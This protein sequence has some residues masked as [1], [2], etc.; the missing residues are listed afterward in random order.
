MNNS[1]LPYPKKFQEVVV[2]RL[3]NRDNVIEDGRLFWWDEK[4]YLFASEVNTKNSMSQTASLFSV[5]D[6]NWRITLNLLYNSDEM[7]SGRQKN[8]MPIPDKPF[9][10]VFS[11]DEHSTSILD[12]NARTIEHIPH[13]INVCPNKLMG[14]TPLFKVGDKYITIVHTAVDKEYYHYMCVFDQNLSLEHISRRFVF[15]KF[16]PVEFAINMFQQNR[17]NNIGITVTEMDS[18]QYVYLVNKDRLMEFIY[19]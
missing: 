18:F 11:V 17:T 1:F 10:M 3:S 14:N 12:L 5:E 16:F 6:N 8:W 13:K 2:P 19:S 7:F 9:K 4:L 15:D